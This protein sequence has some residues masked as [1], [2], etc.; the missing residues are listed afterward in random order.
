MAFSCVSSQRRR[1]L[2]VGIAGSNPAEGMVVRLLWLLCFVQIAAVA[3]SWPLVQR[4]PAVC[5]CVFLCVCVCVSSFVCSRSLN[6]QKAYPSWAVVPQ[7]KGDIHC[8][9]RYKSNIEVCSH[10]HCCN[11]RAMSTIYSECVSVAL[12]FQHAVLML[13]IVLHLWPVWL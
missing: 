10:N 2:I 12:V 8:T 4:S 9:R 6:N 13:R 11:G 3:T 1:S 5:V 7:K